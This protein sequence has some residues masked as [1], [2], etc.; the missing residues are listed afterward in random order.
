MDNNLR[1]AKSSLVVLRLLFRR[2]L[3]IYVL[4][5]ILD[6]SH[7]SWFTISGWVSILLFLLVDFLVVRVLLL[8]LLFSDRSFFFSLSDFIL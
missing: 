6:G 4:S 2:A 5:S 8:F 3:H 7:I 1:C